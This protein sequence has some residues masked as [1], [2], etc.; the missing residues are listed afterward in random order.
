MS[1]I[2]LCYAHWVAG[3]RKVYNIAVATGRDVNRVCGAQG[4]KQNGAPSIFFFTNF[5][6]K[7]NPLEMTAPL[8]MPMTG[9][10]WLLR[11]S[12][13]GL[14]FMDKIHEMYLCLG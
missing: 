13:V 14:I 4:K 1:H 9:R 5:C 11:S 6:Q 2:S 10:N 7:V 3:C 8:P 12:L